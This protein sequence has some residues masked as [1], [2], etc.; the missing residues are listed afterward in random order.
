MTINGLKKGPHSPECVSKPLPQDLGPSTASPASV[1][2]PKSP[3][4]EDSD[5]DDPD[6]PINIGY[7]AFLPHISEEADQPSWTLAASSS[8]SHSAYGYTIKYSTVWSRSLSLR[9]ASD[10]HPHVPT[11]PLAKPAGVLDFQLPF[12]GSR[13]LIWFS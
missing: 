8:P 13:R 9:N 12:S 5:T 4:L 7:S 3:T 1:N 6:L 11:G 10:T 2:L